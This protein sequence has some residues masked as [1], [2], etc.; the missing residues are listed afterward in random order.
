[1]ATKI[2]VE[3][4][5]EAIAGQKSVDVKVRAAQPGGAVSNVVTLKVTT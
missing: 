2:E 1:M 5:R 3:V 4:P